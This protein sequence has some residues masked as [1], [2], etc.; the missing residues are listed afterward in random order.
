MI[1]KETFKLSSGANGEMVSIEVEGEV[2]DVERLA[3]YLKDSLEDT[4]STT[5]KTTSIQRLS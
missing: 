3:Q 5:E 4:V 2:D 1:T